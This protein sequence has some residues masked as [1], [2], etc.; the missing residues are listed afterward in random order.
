MKVPEIA[1]VLTE[2]GSKKKKVQKLEFA[3][4]DTLEQANEEA[5]E[6]TS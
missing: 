3:I 5:K 6:P 1:K 4:R 2:S